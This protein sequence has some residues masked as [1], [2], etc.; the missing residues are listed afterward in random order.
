MKSK[1]L[2]FSILVAAALSSQAITISQWIFETSPPSDLTDSATISGIAADF[3]IGF[4]SGTHAS[5][6]T[7]WTTPAGNGSANSLNA[8]NWSVGDYFQFQ[9]STI[10]FTGVSVSYD[11][12]SSSTGP[13]RFNFAYSTDG[14]AFTTVS[15]NYFINAISWASGSVNSGSSLAFNLAPFASVNN[16]PTVYFRIS[17]ADSSTASGGTVASTGTSRIDNFTVTGNAISSVPDSLPLGFTAIFLLGF[18]AFSH[19]Q[20]FNPSQKPIL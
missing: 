17:E 7:D 10:G 5:S 6:A 19:Y 14:T 16:S 4:A 11:Q 9:V 18:L 13:S 2:F 8:N 20:L 15:A 1:I 3:G 12:T